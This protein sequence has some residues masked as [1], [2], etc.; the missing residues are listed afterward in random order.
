MGPAARPRP[1]PSL[2]APCCASA[3]AAQWDAGPGDWYTIAGDAATRKSGQSGMWKTVAAGPWLTSGR[4]RAEFRYDGGGATCGV[5]NGHSGCA[6]AFGM[7]YDGYDLTQATGHN[8]VSGHDQQIGKGVEFLGN[9]VPAARAA[10]DHTACTAQA[11]FA[12]Q[13]CGGGCSC[14]NG[15][16]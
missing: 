13:T 1:P 14:W 12:T 2:L 10:C 16:G 9:G 5:V 4:C 6:V 15:P 3:A 7:I 8:S 11:P